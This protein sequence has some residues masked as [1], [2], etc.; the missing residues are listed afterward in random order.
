MKKYTVDSYNSEAFGNL[1]FT[2]Q[3]KDT[4]MKSNT[5]RDTLAGSSW[6]DM[7]KIFKIL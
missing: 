1:K 3:P 7:I 2:K 6:L 4:I 5:H